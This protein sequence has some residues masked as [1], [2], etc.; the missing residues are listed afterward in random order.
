[1]SNRDL[2]VLTIKAAS[3]AG[4]VLK[5][6]GKSKSY[7]VGGKGADDFLFERVLEQPLVRG[8]RRIMGKDLW[9]QAESQLRAQSLGRIGGTISGGKSY[10][11]RGLRGKDLREVVN[12]EE[13]HLKPIIGNSETLA[14]IAG[15]ARRTKGKAFD[16]KGA[17]KSYAHLWKTRPG[18]AAIEHGAAGTAGVAGYSGVKS[19]KGNNTD[20][21]EN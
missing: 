7:I 13:F 14:H 17:T 12:H 4:A 8:V 10:T 5:R 15:G 6:I 2:S 3:A 18:R 9:A 20:K 11:R 19:I 21:I 16:A 1:M